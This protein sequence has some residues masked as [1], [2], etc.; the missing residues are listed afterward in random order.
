MKL[1]NNKVWLLTGVLLVTACGG[2]GGGGGSSSAPAPLNNNTEQDGALKTVGSEQAFLEAFKTATLASADQR[3]AED[4]DNTLT[5]DSS[6]PVAAPEASDDRAG[7]DT[8]YSGTYT[9]EANVDEYDIVKYDGEHLFVGKSFGYSCCFLAE[10][11]ALDADIAATD[12]ALQAPPVFTEPENFEAI[13]I[14]STDPTTSSASYVSGIEAPTNEYVM[15]MYLH[16]DQLITLSSPQFFGYFGDVW[17]GYA[18]WQEQ[19]T[20]FKTYDVSDVAAV[21]Q[22]DTIRIEGGFVESRRVG[23]DIV[24]ITRHM[25]QMP[26]IDFYAV[27]DEAVAT[28]ESE[29]DQLT[30]A[31][32]IPNITINGQS[33]AL[34]NAA[35]CLVN[36]EALVGDRQAYP[37]ITSITKMP[38]NQ[39]ENFETVCVTEETHGLY[40]SQT[41]VYLTQMHG[42]N[43]GDLSRIHKFSF[44][45][46]IRYQGSVDIE[47]YVWTGGQSD[48]RMN[49]FDGQLR[50]VTTEYT[51]DETDRFDYTVY[52][53][54]EAT[55]GLALEQ[56]SQLPNAANPQEI[57]KEGERLFGVRFF[58]ERAYLITFE[59]IDPLYVLDL[60]DAAAPIIAG[61]LEIPGVSEFLHPVNDDLLLG[62]GTAGAGDW[63]LKL[64][65]FDVSDIT[66]PDS[67]NAVLIG[68]ANQYSFSG[69]IYN[70]H[71][72]SYLAGD[73]VDR[74]ALPT[75]VSGTV[76]GQYVSEHSLMM[77]EVDKANDASLA[78]IQMVGKV[79]A[80]PKPDDEYFYYENSR[81][82][83][84]GDAV[85]FITGAYVWSA[86]W[87][88]TGQQQ[89][90]F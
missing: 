40:V 33:Q 66:A 48:F 26:S 35:D 15:G 88:S 53:L 34:F 41:S 36:N 45:E 16:S 61:E 25:P 72:F 37:V 73:T 3:S 51:D 19:S 76:E 13:R 46:D 12:L 43:W 18:G 64:E 54:D 58:G 8:N 77:F 49:E 67:L 71:A 4:A 50:V 78:S 60:A 44:A 27:S 83:L 9:L 80:D 22:T 21:S 86:P 81:G 1:Q 68:D 69:A 20:L 52:V 42:E 75:T 89:G 74:L 39:P 90:P 55:E 28:N 65:L 38:I 10:P 63:R 47:G 17:M 5:Q 84:H 2:G 59:Q 56:V 23:D 62:L 70:R 57:G 24:V 6:A 31:D 7:S 79:N 82:V 30:V 85:Y 32:I 29:I 11:L 87:A 14:L